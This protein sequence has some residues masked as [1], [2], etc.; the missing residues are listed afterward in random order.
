[1]KVGAILLHRSLR[2]SCLPGLELTCTSEITVTDSL[3]NSL[4]EDADW[5]R[6]F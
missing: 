3:G 1:M 2:P 6:W 4:T 5:Q